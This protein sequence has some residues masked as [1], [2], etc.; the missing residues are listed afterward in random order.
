LSLTTP[1]AARRLAT[2]VVSADVIANRCPSAQK[3]IGW[4]QLW[5]SLK[6]KA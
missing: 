3:N 5:L 4:G 2:P 1:Y 6:L